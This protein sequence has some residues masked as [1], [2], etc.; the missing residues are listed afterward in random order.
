MV[1]SARSVLSTSNARRNF[2]DAFVVTCSWSACSVLST[3]NARRYL[4][5]A[6]ARTCSWLAHSVLSTSNALRH[7]ACGVCTYV[8]VFGVVVCRHDSPH[9]PRARAFHCRHRYCPLVMKGV[10]L[11][12]TQLVYIADVA[13]R[14]ASTLLRSANTLRWQARFVPSAKTDR[15]VIST[16]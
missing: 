6:F 13:W 8:F 1:L 7:P 16:P 12:R 10:E 3:S 2:F 9:R 4:A 5:F 11:M 15:F 14:T